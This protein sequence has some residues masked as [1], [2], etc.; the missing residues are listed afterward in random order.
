[1]VGSAT[2]LEGDMAIAATGAGTAATGIAAAGIGR[3][4]AM[5]MDMDIRDT[6]VKSEALRPESVL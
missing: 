6:V 5:D 1:M 3:P 2:T 4:P